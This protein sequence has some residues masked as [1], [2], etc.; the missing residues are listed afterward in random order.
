MTESRKTHPENERF[1]QHLYRNQN[2]L[3]T[4]LKHPGL[5]ATH[6][7]AEQAIR[8]AVVN[9]KVWG[10]SR[11]ETGA[12]AQSILMSIL[13]TAAKREIEVIDWLSAKLTNPVITQALPPPTR[14]VLP[15]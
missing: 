14:R 8:P 13:G 2:H 10:G 7:K 9:R 3:F 4:F 12:Q 1:A 11:T 5:D 6:H 15:G